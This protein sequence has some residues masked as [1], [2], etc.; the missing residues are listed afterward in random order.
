MTSGEQKALADFAAA[1]RKHYGDR[2]E[3][4]LL[5]GSRARGDARPDSD[6]DVIVVLADG[7]WSFWSEPRVLA[8]L[9]YEPLIAEGIAIHPW[10]ISRSAWHDQ[11]SEDSRFVENAQ[12]DAK[13]FQETA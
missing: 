11:S 8:E 4:I 5:F 2:L 9:A 10:P 1:V 3:D 13:S 12:W 6:A 7:P